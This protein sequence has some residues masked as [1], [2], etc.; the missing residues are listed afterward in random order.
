M[1]R[2]HFLQSQPEFLSRA[3][4]FPFI[5]WVTHW[6]EICGCHVCVKVISIIILMFISGFKGRHLPPAFAWKFLAMQ[7]WG[8]WCLFFWEVTFFQPRDCMDLR[9]TDGALGH[10]GRG[11]SGVLLTP[12]QRNTDFLTGG[13][14]PAHCEQFCLQILVSY[15]KEQLSSKKVATS[16]DSFSC[17]SF[18]LPRKF[19]LAS[20]ANFYFCKCYVFSMAQTGK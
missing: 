16:A 13:P 4:V 5:N 6:F 2:L 18:H 19:W 10:R 14:I 3:S 20:D 15:K 9:L 1:L 8:S 7:I 17:L 11:F 12:G